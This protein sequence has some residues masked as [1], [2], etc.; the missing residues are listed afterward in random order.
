MFPVGWAQGVPVITYMLASMEV[1]TSFRSLYHLQF[2]LIAAACE[3]YSAPF[4]SCAAPMPPQHSCHWS[5]V[6]AGHRAAFQGVE[7]FSAL[8][9]MVDNE[10][11]IVVLGHAWED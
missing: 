8:M 3:P 4:C 6:Y 5:K 9:S 7:R 10:S 11:A 1:V 2:L